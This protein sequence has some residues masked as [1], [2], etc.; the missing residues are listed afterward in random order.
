MFKIVNICILTPENLIFERKSE[1][2]I[3]DIDLNKNFTYIDF[4]KIFLEIRYLIFFNQNP[5]EQKF[6][7]TNFVIFS[8]LSNIF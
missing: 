4:T 6:K 8:D 1:F 2:P 5:L 7:H 3:T